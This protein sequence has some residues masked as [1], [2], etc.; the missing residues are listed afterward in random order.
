MLG[1]VADIGPVRGENLVGLA[2]EQKVERLLEHRTHGLLQGFVFTPVIEHPP[3]VLEAAGRIFFRAA[4]RLHD[5]VETDHC[6]R[7]DFSHV[8]TP[9]QGVDQFSA[10]MKNSDASSDAAVGTEFQFVHSVRYCAQTLPPSALSG[11]TA[12]SALLSGTLP[13]MVTRKQPTT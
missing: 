3:A 4:R 10:R 5:T 1:V 13:S 8:D 2:A 7:N 6:H 9:L 11:A 12:A